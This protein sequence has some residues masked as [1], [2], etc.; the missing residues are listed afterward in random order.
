MAKVTEDP[1]RPKAAYTHGSTIDCSRFRLLQ[2]QRLQDLTTERAP[3]A[4]VMTIDDFP[5]N[6]KS[7]NVTF[8]VDYFS[9]DVP[10][11]DFLEKYCGD[12]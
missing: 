1:A 3:Y 12:K 9:R 8:S 11:P 6:I 4:D 5:D 2:Q 7:E 10:N